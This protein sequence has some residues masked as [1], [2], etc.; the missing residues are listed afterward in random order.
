MADQPRGLYEILITQALEARLRSLSEH[1]HAE[2][3]SLRPAEAADR[4]ALHIGRIVL[5]VLAGVEESER[6]AVGVMLAQKLLERVDALIAQAGTSPDIPIAP[7]MVLRAVLRRLPDGTPEALSEPLIP[8]LDSALLTNAP[9]EP[10]VGHQVV[11][12]IRSADRIDLVMAFIRRSGISPMLDALRSHCQSGRELRVLTTTYTG[13]T[14]ARALDELRALGANVRVSYDTSTTRLHAKAWLF[15]RRSGFSTAYIGSSNL[16][17]TAQV[18]GLEWNVRVSGARNPDIVEKVAAVF[19][20]YWHGDDFVPYDA[21]EFASRI[22]RA[23]SGG[24][25][26]ILSPIELRPEPF[27]ERLLEQIALSRERGHHRNLLVSAT[28]TGKTVMAA[29][30]YARLRARL[31]RAQRRTSSARLVR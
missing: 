29:V 31:P 7:G 1:L 24:P 22:D 5:R 30:D 9:G 15:H 8:L 18:T 28:G 16:T 6:V 11:A 23:S 10:R 21:A 25:T 14:E 13:S 2:T 19:E 3:G 26:V 20:G 17:H 27:Q 4:I 12:E